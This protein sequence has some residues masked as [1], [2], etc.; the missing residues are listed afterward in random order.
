MTINAS[1]IRKMEIHRNGR[2]ELDILITFD[3]MKRLLQV[4]FGTELISY[5]WKKDQVSA[6]YP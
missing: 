2:M 1:C 6:L 5:K 4:D 3:V